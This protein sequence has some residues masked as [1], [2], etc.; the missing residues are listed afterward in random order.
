MCERSHVD[1]HACRTR[2]PS[3]IKIVQIHRGISAIPLEER[4]PLIVLD[5]VARTFE[6]RVAPFLTDYQLLSI[7]APSTTWRISF[8]SSENF[9]FRAASSNPFSTLQT[10][11]HNFETSLNSLSV[12]R[13]VFP[14]ILPLIFKRITQ[15]SNFLR[16]NK[17]NC[18]ACGERI[19]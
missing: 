3:F 10:R 16:F 19:C 17:R 7:G 5:I 18:P 8:S 13:I 1:T 2:W 14:T 15:R 6:R 4:F 12:A 11:N 9:Y